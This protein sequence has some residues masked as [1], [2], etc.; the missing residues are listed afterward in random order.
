MSEN[1]GAWTWNGM[2]QEDFGNVRVGKASE[3]GKMLEDCGKRRKCRSAEQE[4]IGV[5]KT[6][7]NIGNVGV[8]NRKTSETLECEIGMEI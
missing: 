1:V 4:N 3:C 6:L 7:E 8:W 2:E 5:W